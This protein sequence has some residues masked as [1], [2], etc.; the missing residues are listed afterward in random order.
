MS[1]RNFWRRQDRANCPRDSCPVAN[2][3]AELDVPRATSTAV[4]A[5]GL[6]NDRA[7]DTTVVKV[8]PVAPPL[9]NLT[10]LFGQRGSQ[11]RLDERFR[12]WFACQL[13]TPVLLPS[14][15]IPGIVLELTPA[16]ALIVVP[17]RL[18]AGDSA[19]AVQLHSIKGRAQVVP[20]AIE[21]GVVFHERATLLKLSFTFATEQQ[22]GFVRALVAEMR[23]D[24]RRG[25]GEWSEYVAGADK[26]CQASVDEIS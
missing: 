8:T 24:S 6:T 4:Q 26:S 18:S 10:R 11:A 23:D 22:R 3:F 20:C 25:R 21:R 13:L 9:A 1:V 14:R 2:A 16:G 19:V 7:V 5:A 17:D 15:A 12:P